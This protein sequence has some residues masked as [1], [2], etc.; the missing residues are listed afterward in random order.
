MCGYGSVRLP[1]SWL[2]RPA[3][4]RDRPRAEP[5]RAQHPCISPA[6]RAASLALL[7]DAAWAGPAAPDG[8][9]GRSGPASV[10]SGSCPPWRSCGTPGRAGGRGTRRGTRRLRDGGGG[11]RRRGCGSSSARSWS[12]SGARG[13]CGGLRHTQVTLLWIG[14]AP[15]RACCNA[16][17]TGAGRSD[18]YPQAPVATLNLAAHERA[19]LS[20]LSTELCVVNVN[21]IWYGIVDACL[22]DLEL[23]KLSH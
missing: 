10:A 5:P 17:S 9:R 2:A 7:R 8:P 11:R 3:S 6:T 13:R 22:L 23:F 14:V 21:I 4:A 19:G 15:A 18:P 1:R 16:Y 12:A 20:L